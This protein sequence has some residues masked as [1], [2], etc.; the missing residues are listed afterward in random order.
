MGLATHTDETA[1]LTDPKEDKI[2]FIEA[3]YDGKCSET[4]KDIRSGDLIS[5]NKDGKSVLVVWKK[6]LNQYK[7]AIN[8]CGII[9]LTNELS[10]LNGVQRKCL[11]TLFGNQ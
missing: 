10:G 7:S 1:A 3:K 11:L 9:L 5:W 2:M 4:G 8:S 6:I